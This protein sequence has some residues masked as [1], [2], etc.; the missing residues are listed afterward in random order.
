M[1]SRWFLNPWHVW[2]I[3][4]P[5]LMCR[6]LWP[7]NVEITKTCQATVPHQVV[8]LPIPFKLLLGTHDF[9]AAIYHISSAT[10]KPQLSWDNSYTQRLKRLCH[11]DVLSLQFSH[12]PEKWTDS[13]N[14]LMYSFLEITYPIT[15]VVESV[16]KSSQ[17]VLEIFQR[18]CPPFGLLDATN[19]SLKPQGC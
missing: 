19:L 7:C 13:S 5:V 2:T 1:M 18:C 8:L 15:T 4:C 14:T 16:G 11:I 9:T 6:A 3:E 17:F 10:Q 12:S